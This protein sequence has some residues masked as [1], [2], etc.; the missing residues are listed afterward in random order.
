MVRVNPV[1]N[2][3]RGRYRLSNQREDEGGDH[4]ARECFERAV[5]LDPSRGRAWNNLGAARQRPGDRAGAEA[6]YYRA[7]GSEPVLLQPH[8]NLGRLHE[9]RGALAETATRYR[10]ALSHHPGDERLAHLLAAAS[11]QNP[12]RAP[13]GYVQALFD[14][15]APRFESHLVQDL[16]YA[17]PDRLAELLGPVLVA[18]R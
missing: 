9:A 10:A 15:E 14:S 17:V 1:P 18:R 2:D 4:E 8:L 3:A 5:A 12:A 6:A 13:H 7:I 16:G 11:G